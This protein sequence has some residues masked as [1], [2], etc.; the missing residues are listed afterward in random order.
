M[1]FLEEVVSF[2]IVEGDTVSLE[3]EE[4]YEIFFP[5]AVVAFVSYICT[6]PFV[7]WRNGPQAQ[8]HDSDPV[9]CSSAAVC[10]LCCGLSLMSKTEAALF[11]VPLHDEMMDRRRAAPMRTPKTTSTLQGIY[12][13][14]ERN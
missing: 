4:R 10:S 13:D 2:P 12:N 7:R 11:S 9:D 8:Q 14:V 6:S 1:A 5:S 3:K